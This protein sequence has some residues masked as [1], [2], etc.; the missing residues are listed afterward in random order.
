MIS[1]TSERFWRLYGSLPSDA[2][3]AARKAFA[4]W[5]DNP[6]HPSLRFKPLRGSGN[7]WS[8]RVGQQYRAVGVREGDTIIWFWIGTHNEFDKSF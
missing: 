6:N 1:L 5:A 7:C 2:K 3:D 8:V 4:L